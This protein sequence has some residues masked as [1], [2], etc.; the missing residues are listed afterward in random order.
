M[1]NQTADP[2]PNIQSTT[3]QEQQQQQLQYPPEY[4]KYRLRGIVIH[5]GSAEMGHYYSIIKSKQ[6]K[7]HKKKSLKINSRN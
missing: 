1:A 6:S 7:F 4:Y 2:I 3:S 5:V